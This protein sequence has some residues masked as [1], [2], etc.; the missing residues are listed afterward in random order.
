MQLDVQRLYDASVALHNL[1]NQRQA[2]LAQ[3]PDA[4]V[5]PFQRA[6]HGANYIGE[7][8]TA[9]VLAEELA[10]SLEEMVRLLEE[11]DGDAAQEIFEAD[12]VPGLA[13]D[14]LQ[15]MAV[16]VLAY[17]DG[18]ADRLFG[19]YSLADASSRD[20]AIFDDIVDLLE[21]YE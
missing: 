13:Y 15:D 2:R 20:W 19:A 10:V 6:L 12:S 7:N 8:I 4:Y 1:S 11:K 14:I 9:G 16:D 18:E 21:A 5:E 17:S 3:L